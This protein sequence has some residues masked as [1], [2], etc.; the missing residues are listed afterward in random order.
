MG[1]MI[2]IDTGSGST[3]AYLAGDKDAGLPGVLFYIDGIG[4]RPQ[5]K[6]MADRVASWGYVVLAP[7]VF[8]RTGTA[9]ELEPKVDLREPGARDDFFQNGL[10]TRFPDLTTAG[11]AQDAD[12]YVATLRE[13]AG[14]GPIAVTGYCMGVRLATRTAGQFPETVAAVGGF[15]G[16]QLATDADDSPHRSIAM[17]TAEYVYGHADNDGSM[18]PEQVAQL[19]EALTAADRPHVNE[20]YAGAV[21]GYTMADTS[22]YS[23][24]AAERHFAALQGLLERTIA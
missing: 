3:E 11:A 8:Y 1:E 9:E 13:H 10:G 16:G 19:E 20:I 2:T 24:A 5:I 7:N 17:S 23:E 4:L 18:P 22:M 21:H 14:E 12:A 6:E 15:H